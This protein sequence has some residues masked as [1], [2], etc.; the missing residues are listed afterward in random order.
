MGRKLLG[1]TAF[2]GVTAVAGVTTA[3]FAASSYYTWRWWK[4]SD[5]EKEET[6]ASQ[7]HHY[8]DDHDEV[9]NHDISNLNNNHD[10]LKHKHPSRES[11]ESEIRRMRSSPDYDD[12]ESEMLNSYYNP[13]LGGWFVGKSKN[14]W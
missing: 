10:H 14:N 5:E 1:V 9:N 11:A 3:V 4:S 7:D 12:D 8:N 6:Q 2:L 13:K